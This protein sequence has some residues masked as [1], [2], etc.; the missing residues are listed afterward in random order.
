MAPYNCSVQSGALKKVPHTLCVVSSPALR[1]RLKRSLHASGAT[2]EFCDSVTQASGREVPKLLFLD[3]QSRQD[4]E[5]PHLLQ[6]M[7]KQGKVVII[8]ES[9]ADNAFVQLMRQQPFD[10]VMDAEE[11]DESEILVTSVKLLTG[12]IF[13]L[14]KYLGWGADMT[15]SV[16]RDYEGKRD[17]LEQV[18]AFAKESGARRKILGRIE[19][20]ADELLM[21]AIYDAPAAAKA[22]LSG[23]DNLHFEVGPNQAPDPG[24][25][26]ATLTFGCDGRYFG[27]SVVDH[28]GEL[29]KKSILDNL[30]RARE[31]GGRP[32]AG[33][34]GAGLGIFFVLA[35]ASRYIANIHQG[36]KTEVICL[37]DMR[38][39][40]REA[41]SC[42]GSLHIFT[43]DGTKPS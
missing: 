7:D 2:V 33:A 6:V 32:R 34:S 37:F 24:A 35:S 28:Y 3:Q 13:G 5:L 4:A 42:T 31:S 1:R 40:G 14:D 11:P 19:N 15:T 29:R 30:L 43:A 23:Q 38:L 10:H 21:N 17:A 26:P 25:K 9:I 12:D 20:V 36:V 18:A 22:G 41:Q 27:M 16:V 39:T 8:G